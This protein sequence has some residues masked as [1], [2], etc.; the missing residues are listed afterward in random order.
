VLDPFLRV[1]ANDPVENGISTDTKK[2]LNND[3]AWT[4]A[5]LL[6]MVPVIQQGGVNYR[7]FL[8][9][10]NQT[11][12]NP[13][14]SLDEV[15]LFLTS[16]PNITSYV[17]GGLTGGGT[18]NGIAYNAYSGSGSRIG[19]MVFS[20]GDNIVELNYSLEAGSGKPDMT[21]LVPDSVFGSPGDPEY[22]GYAQPGCNTWMGF[23]SQFGG[24][25]G[26]DISGTDS[27]WPNN[28]G[29][30]EWATILRPV[31]LVSRMAQARPA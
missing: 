30:E 3:D 13:L 31:V 27:T 9:D 29:F 1:S 23:Y 18:L 20:Q 24:W 6:S 5:L 21:L 12:S 25:N 4:K 26:T 19:T 16:T 10:I 15:K 7:E 8:L 11:N 2:V 28:D 22:C 17:D 14:L